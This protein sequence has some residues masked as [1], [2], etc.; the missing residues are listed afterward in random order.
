ME[1]LALLRYTG[2]LV[3]GIITLIGYQFI[4]ESE[5]FDSNAAFILVTGVAF[6]VILQRSRFCFF[7]ILR[8]LF[9]F[10]N[11][12]PLAGLII[13]LL[14]GSIGYLV[15]FGAWISDPAAGHLP[16][17]AH[18]GPVSWHLL[19][20]GLLFGWGMALSGS[21]ISAH[22]YRIGEGSMI[23]PF[24]LAGS[25]IGFILGYISWNYLYVTTISGAPVTWLPEF[26]GYS[27]TVI[28]QSGVLLAV[29]LWLL[30]TF[31][32]PEQE[33]NSGSPLT[34]KKITDRV[35]IQRWPT[36]T[37]GIG[38]GLIAMFAYFRV[39]P[40]GVTAEI[41]RVSRNTGDSLELIPGRLEGLDGFA[42]CTVQ[43]EPAILSANGIFI[44]AL[45]AGALISALIAGQF[46]PKLVSFAKVGKGFGGGI[47]LGFG[48]MISLGCTIG[49]TLSGIMAFAVSGWVFTIAMVAGVWSGIKMNWH[50]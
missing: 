45:V 44:V 49:T 38:V 31:S 37:G 21:C 6:G 10:K 32:A 4:G 3:V 39:E 34:L 5:S 33:K 12:K 16:Q 26:A 48:A 8:D 41:G 17:D 7:C 23:A 9:E 25:V 13:A 1:R 29:L 27:W 43:T 42:G 46:K 19:L 28:L 2:A 20:G 35:F 11:G 40:L 22:F 14:I 47:L 36:W 50:R 30:I 18:I 24:A 15:I